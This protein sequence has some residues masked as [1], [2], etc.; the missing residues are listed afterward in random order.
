MQAQG[1]NP[2]LPTPFL[3]DGALDIPSLRRLIDFQKTAGVNGVAILGF[4]GE[5]HKLSE[6]ERREVIEVV[7]DQSGS[8][9]DVWVGVRALGTMGAVEQS[10]TAQAA[11]AD[12]VFV[13]PI[14][15]Q[16]DE[17]LYQHFKTVAEAVDIPVM[18]HDFPSSFNTILSASLIAQLGRDGHCPYIKLEDPPIGPKMSQIAALSEGAVG[19]FGGLGGL[20]F[21][22]ELERGA[23]GIMTG[24]SFPE[25]L[26]QIYNEHRRGDVEQA[27]ATFDHYASLIRYEF[28]PKIGLAYR[29]HIYHKRGIFSTTT[30]RPPAMEL[31][32]Y[33]AAELERTMARAGMQ[34]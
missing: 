28:Q 22:E 2:I 25:V 19:V 21:L 23:L 33:S 12:A 24:F 1:V 30:V 8:E 11:G 15:I 29:K 32:A 6:A 5:A 16:N 17:G 7:V 9:L 13:A 4:M 18:I 31:D 26:V 14:D 34:I 27:R 3:S 20:Y 10:Q